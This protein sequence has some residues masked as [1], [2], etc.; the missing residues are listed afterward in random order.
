[1]PPRLHSQQLFAD[2]KVV[3]IVHAGREYRLRITAANKL[4]LTT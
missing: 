2:G 3:V 1:M 4:I